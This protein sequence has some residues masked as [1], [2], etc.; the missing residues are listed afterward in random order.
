MSNPEEVARLYYEALN[1]DARPRRSPARRKRAVHGAIET[2]GSA[3]ELRGMLEGLVANVGAGKV[4][5]KSQA[6]AGSDVLSF[7]DFDIGAPGGPVQMA[8]RLTVRDGTVTAVQL[9][10]DARRLGD[11]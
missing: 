9:I 1:G 11:G 2:V 6:V 4:T 7:Y 10:S 5:M 8:E 3:T